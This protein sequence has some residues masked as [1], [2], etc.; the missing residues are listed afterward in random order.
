MH[1]A[2]SVCFAVSLPSHHVFNVWCR[3]LGIHM[4]M[5]ELECIANIRLWNV[6]LLLLS[7]LRTPYA[8]T[9]IYLVVIVYKYIFIENRPWFVSYSQTKLCRRWYLQNI[10]EKIEIVCCQQPVKR[11]RDIFAYVFYY[12]SPMIDTRLLAIV[13]PCI[14]IAAAINTFV[15]KNINLVYIFACDYDFVS[16]YHCCDWWLTRHT[17]ATTP[18]KTIPT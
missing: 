8:S 6:L 12:R 4:R 16:I 5:S 1:R 10:R 3:C 13:E 11:K 15:I 18:T 17:T 9:P 14:C 2:R 7:W